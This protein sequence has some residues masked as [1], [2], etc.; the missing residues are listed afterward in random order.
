LFVYE[1]SLITNLQNIIIMDSRLLFDIDISS[2]TYESSYSYVSIDEVANLD[3]LLEK[4][5]LTTNLAHPFLPLLGKILRTEYERKKN[6][7][8]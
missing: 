6:T 2:I 5:S 8:I 4:L 1:E 7:K 3:L